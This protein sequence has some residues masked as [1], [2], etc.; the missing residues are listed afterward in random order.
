M[1]VTTNNVPRDLLSFH[2]AQGT[3]GFD[4]SDFDYI[5]GDERFYPRLF[6]YRSYW[7]DTHEFVRIAPAGSKVY[8]FV[9]HDISGDLEGWDGIQTDS[10]FSAVVLRWARD[11]YGQMDHERVVVGL[12]LS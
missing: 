5:E 12:A 4:P 9:H 3:R 1:N 2:E 8:G 10:Y 6:C 7:Y 11:E